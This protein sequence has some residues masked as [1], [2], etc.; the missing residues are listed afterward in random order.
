M[1]LL[2]CRT[3]DDLR[4]PGTLSFTYAGAVSGTFSAIGDLNVV[5]AGA[6]AYNY[7]WATGKSFN[8]S[9]TRWIAILANA[10]AGAGVTTT[11]QLEGAPAQA[12]TFPLAGDDLNLVIFGLSPT[13]GDSYTFTSG[14]M[15]VSELTTTRARGTFSGTAQ[16][17]PDGPTVVISD[18]TFDVAVVQ[19]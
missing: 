19:Q 13:T 15:T 17:L 1:A 12:A 10:P 14:S 8:E 9:G 3:V 16:R 4:A 7:E 18:G 5:P 6:P 11:I 2:S